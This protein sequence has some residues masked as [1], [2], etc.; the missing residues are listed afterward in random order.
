MIAGV[1]QVKTGGRRERARHTRLKI[2]RAAH[3]EFLK[4]GYHGATVAAIARRA[5]VAPQTVYFVFHTK[6]ELIRAA[7]DTAVLGEDDPTDPEQTDWWV[8]MRAAPTGAEAL[9]HFVRGAGPLYARAAGISEILRAAALT[10]PDVHAIWRHHDQQQV[11]AFRR[12]IETVATRG[13]LR[14]GL[15]PAAATDILLTVYGDSTYLLLTAERGWTHNQV[16]DWA[17]QA[18]TVLLLEPG[19]ERGAG[20]DR[21]HL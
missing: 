4:H 15:E 5:A 6:A 21:E 17:C 1:S 7:I 10:D 9:E 19:S 13:S 12:V 14:S 16:I 20:H 2:I 11:A 3:A 8:A 18:L